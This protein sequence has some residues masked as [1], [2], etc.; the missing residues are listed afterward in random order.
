MV[1]TGHNLDDEAAVLFGNV[2]RWHT[3]YLG[4]QLPVLPAANGFPRKVKPLVRLGEREMAAYCVVRGIDYIVEEC[5]MAVGNKHLGYKDALNAIEA[6]SPGSKHDFY[7]GFLSRASER[8]PAEAEQADQ[9]G[10]A[11]SLP[12]R[13]GAPTPARRLRLLPAG[14][15]GRRSGPGPVRGRAQPGRRGSMSRAVAG[16]RAGAAHRQQ[17]PPLPGHAAGRRRVPLPRRVRGPRRHR[18]ATRGRHRPLDPGQGY[19]VLRPTLSDFILKMPRGAQVIYPKD[20]GP[21]LVAGR[22]H[23]GLRVLESGV[24]SGALSMTMLRAGATVIGYELRE[25]F[26]DRA[27]TN[28]ASFLGE[29]ALDRYRVEIRDCYDGIDEP[30]FDRIVLDLPEP[31]QV[32]PH[33]ATA[34]APGGILSPTRRASPRPPSCA[35]RSTSAL[36][37]GRDPRGAPAQLAHRGPGGA[38][39]PPHGGPHRLPDPRSPGRALIGAALSGRRLAVLGQ[40]RRWLR[41][42]RLAATLAPTWVGVGR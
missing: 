25:D 8:F 32:V 15:A 41:R 4:R 34:L 10:D 16:G 24:G 1:A 14:G 35:R 21:I 7:F 38:P 12:R 33:A 36:R 17:E 19:R 11:A 31:W 28:V 30:A 40:S 39:R 23:P 13:C 9:R 37:H 6:T 5:P 20:L 2:L 42:R 26:A 27:R 18:R 3:E 29:E 22:H